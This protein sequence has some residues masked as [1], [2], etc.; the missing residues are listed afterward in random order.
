MRVTRKA[1]ALFHELLSMLLGFL[2][3]HGQ[4]WDIA[5]KVLVYHFQQ[6]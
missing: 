2:G 1:A 5:M 3:A 4:C 6:F